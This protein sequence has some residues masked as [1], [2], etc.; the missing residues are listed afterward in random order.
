MAVNQELQ[1]IFNGTLNAS[2]FNNKNVV[3]D[4]P[5]VGDVLRPDLGIS[6]VSSMSGGLV[7]GAVQVEWME[8]GAGRAPATHADIADNPTGADAWFGFLDSAWDGGA[9]TIVEPERLT[10]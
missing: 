9:I 6:S 2:S 4:I 3:V 8:D 1:I 5:I 10:P 7:A